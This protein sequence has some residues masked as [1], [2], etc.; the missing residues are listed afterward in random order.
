MKIVFAGNFMSHHQRPLSDA[1]YRLTNQQ[2]AFISTEEMHTERKK[3]GWSNAKPPVYELHYYD[4]KEKVECDRWLREADVIIYGAAPYELIE[5]CLKRKQLVFRYAERPY[6][7]PLPWYKYP[8]H[9]V[10]FFWWFR[11]YKNFHLLC[12]SAYAAR[13]FALTGSFWNKAYRWGYFPEIK[14]HVDIEKLLEKKKSATITWVARLIPLKHPEAV[15]EVAKRLKAKGYR[16]T[17]NMIGNGELEGYLAKLIE[18]E[19]VSDCVHALGAMPP[20]TVRKYME[21]SEIFL[22]TSDRNEGWGAVLNESMNS[23]CAVVANHN[24][25]SVPFLLQDKENGLIYKDADLDDLTG[26]VEWLLTHP[27]E[28]RR[29]GRNAYATLTE[30]WNAENAAEKLIVISK[31]ILKGDKPASPFE[32]G[33][34]SPAP[35]LKDNWY[36]I[37]E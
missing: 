4:E 29:L 12:A 16:F 19:D 37:D 27:E 6:K 5:P 32:N 3:M 35:R 28:R 22:F 14:L 26:K 34:C 31:R 36:P 18:Q 25:G 20:E 9:L 24:I 13:D 15:V 2:Y 21:E 33:V 10:K 8:V 23:A 7:Q 11:R 1:L 17:L 30:E